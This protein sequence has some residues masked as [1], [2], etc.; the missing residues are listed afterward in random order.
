MT[1]AVG[2]ASPKLRLVAT[3]A[4][5]ATLYFLTS[6]LTGSLIG[7]P[8]IAVMWP[9]SGVYLG[10]ML[11]APRHMWPALACAAGIGSLAAYLHAGS[12]LE[13]G[14]AFA[15]PSSAEG[16]LGALLV[17]RIAG[18]RFRLG[19]LR[20]LIAL[21]VG[22]LVANA[23]VGLSAGAVAAQ[24]FDAS[25]AESWVRWWSADALGMIAVAPIITGRLRPERRR[26]SRAELRDVACVVAGLGFAVGF[27]AW[28][29]P[30]GAATL[31]GGAIAL[32]FLLWAGWRWGPRAAGLGG[33]GV[34][35]AATHLAPQ[36][37]DAVAYAGSVGN[38]V[39]VVQ[40]FLAVLLLGSLAFAAAVADGRRAET[41]AARTRRRLRRVVDSSPDAYLAIDAD[42]RISDWS[43]GA[44]AMFG[45]DA[46]HALGR[47]L[48]ETIAPDAGTDA[49]TPELTRLEQ[50]DAATRELAL[51]A[52]D[53]G[54]RQ[55]PVKLTVLPASERDDELCHI[56]VRDVAERER[57][58][59]ELA[60]RSAE[61]HQAGR[62]REQLAE[63]LRGSQAE[64]RRTEQELGDARS[65]LAAAGQELDTLREELAARSAELL[66][67]GRG[68]EQLAEDLRG[69]QAE[70]RRTEQELG[71]ARSALAAAGQDL[72]SLREELAARSAE[73]HQAGRGREQLVED[74]HGSQEERRRTE[75]ELGD[76][77]SALAAA[78]QELDTLRRELAL[79]V[80]DRD[81]VHSELDDSARALER[82]QAELGSAAGELAHARA[83]SRALEEE[84]ESARA[85]RAR[86]EEELAG[87]VSWRRQA[88]Q[89]LEQARA[90]FAEDRER[91]QRSLEE[92][93]TG[94]ARAHAERRLLRDHATELISRYDERGTCLYASPA[95]RRLLGYDPEE[96]VGRPGA[97]LLHPDDR[98]RLARAR[99]TRSEST[100]EARL[101][102]K[103]GDFV[104]VEVSLHPVRR[105]GDERLAEINATIRDISD[106]RA[107]E[108]SRRLAQASF[109]SHFG[110]VPIGSAL[111]AR[112]GRLERANPAL[113]RLT[114]YSREQLEGIPLA[115]IVHREHAV[116]CSTGLRRVASGEV[117]TLRLDQQLVHASGRTVPVE[118]SVTPL[119]TGGGPDLTGDPSLRGLVAHFQD[120]TE[121]TRPGTDL[122]RFAAG[123]TPPSQTAA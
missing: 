108:E 120:L 24:T 84:L 115:T 103:A 47:S 5:F 116:S 81:G 51:V 107:A 73:L 122:G 46:A 53:R 19:G 7:D 58:R 105:H 63:D 75:Q 2:S 35:L 97:E 32:P 117:A 93:T 89:A 90:R 95:F 31:V 18:K 118:L 87:A 79:A 112:D 74:L 123:H 21:V 6:A 68:R 106:R 55:F 11:A 72:K 15:V 66:Q 41:A 76:A 43:A 9:A 111:I 22:A 121:R 3:T 98:P 59:E 82:L 52:R 25:F 14:V 17:E 62:G 12:S 49:P 36:G 70:R 71:D 30:A 88:E 100:F 34:A 1:R 69:S 78:G 39:Y 101:R 57:L 91:L 77:R 45:W 20:D 27:A 4:A 113:C 67:A 10:V 56:F 50:K 64:R 8:G 65:A 99:A 94:L 33:V 23:L 119:T 13:V 28:S 37:S 86:T 42:G 96:L 61:L 80:A 114:G 54:G 38:Q 92:T 102:R 109:D 29:E 60:A 40:A 83:G 110:T 48:A 85:E 104:W 26:P 16:L 44:E